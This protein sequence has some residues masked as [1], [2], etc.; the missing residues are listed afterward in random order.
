[1]DTNKR[2]LSDRARYVLE[3][4]ALGHTYE[5]VLQFNQSYT[6]LDIFHAASEAL[7]LDAG[8][9]SDYSQRLLEIRK[10][11]PRAY[12]KWTSEEE[13]RLV[14]SFKA[15]KETSEIADELQRQQ[16][17]ILSRLKRLGLAGN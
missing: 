1:M 10:S 2:H 12:E 3:L 13:E 4:I 16:S 6:Y 11:H 8:D 7:E 5:Q 17:A 15:G 9:V 14:L